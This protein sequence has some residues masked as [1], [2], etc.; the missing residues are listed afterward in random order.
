MA[1]RALS[2]RRA[3]SSALV[4]ALGL[5]LAP[6]VALADCPDGWFCDEAPVRS[7]PAPSAE[8]TPPG[9]TPAEEPTDEP[10]EARPSR[11]RP[12][13]R[14]LLVDG[15]ERPPPPPR[16]VHR[17]R[18]ELGL[19]FHL[20]LGVM[21]AG[22]QND[23]WLGGAGLA[24]RLRPFPMFAVDLGLEIA[25][26]VDYNGNDRAEQ[27]FVGNTL[28]F[29]N[30]RDRVQCFLLG[31]FNLGGANVRVRKQAGYAV[32][33]RDDSYTYVGVQLGLG[34][35]WRVSRRAAITSD[36]E[37]LARGRTDTGRDTNPEYIDPSTHMATND[38][39]GGLFRLGGTLYF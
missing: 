9:E 33:P 26:G 30:P 24:F 6:R 16:R 14:I 32:L 25:G 21:G 36:F 20:D 18:Q 23:S 1:P 19:N 22:A 17:H 12:H 15:P 3:T 13:G 29:L 4:G 31:G 34:V 8:P 10:A 35:E 38:S 39:G 28:V 37:L 2:L 11:R 7:P 5:F 27:A